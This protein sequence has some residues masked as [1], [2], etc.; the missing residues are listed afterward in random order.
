MKKRI[1]LIATKTSY[2][3]ASVESEASSQ[4]VVIFSFS[5]FIQQE[6]IKKF[7]KAFNKTTWKYSEWTY[8]L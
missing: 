7:L 6:N 5:P 8:I 2:S 4:T 1:D 3:K